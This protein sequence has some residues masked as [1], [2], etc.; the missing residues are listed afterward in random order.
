MADR[1]LRDLERAWQESGDPQV[2]ARW[3]R[4]R[5]R[6]GEL[7]PARALSAAYL[8][9]PSAT[10]IAHG[11]SG[12]PATSQNAIPLAAATLLPEDWLRI[13]LAVVRP[14]TGREDLVTAVEDWLADPCRESEA[15][16][17]ELRA[18]LAI[19][20]RALATLALAVASHQD[21]DAAW[22]LW[23]HGLTSSIRSPVVA[24]KR[25]HLG[26]DAAVKRVRTE[27]VPYLL[28]IGDPIRERFKARLNEYKQQE[29]TR[30]SSLEGENE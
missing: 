21:A 30:W 10:L 4:A 8:G 12:L 5:I 18:G 29:T 27:L 6:L 3:L 19:P 25:D 23:Q 17:T 26:W 16:L 15:R 20:E 7:E 22:D 2:G 9:D 1:D 13:L 14:L 28:G 24:G 11:A